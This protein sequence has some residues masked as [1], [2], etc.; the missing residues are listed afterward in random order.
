MQVINIHDAKTHFSKPL[1]WVQD[2]EDVVILPRL[3]DRLRVW[4]PIRHPRAELLPQ[5]PC[6]VAFWM[7]DDFYAPLDGLF[8]CL[9]EST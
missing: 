8:E 2:G 5:G 1:E 3:G 7:A 9:D 6:E 4:C